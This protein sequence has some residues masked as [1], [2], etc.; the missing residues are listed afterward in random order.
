MQKTWK[1]VWN[2][3]TWVFIWD[4]SARALQW[5]QTWKVYVLFKNLCIMVF[6]K[7]IA[8]ALERLIKGAL[9]A[10]I[11]ISLYESN[12]LLEQDGALLFL[13]VIPWGEIFAFCHHPAQP[14]SS[15]G[16]GHVFQMGGRDHF[17]PL[18]LCLSYAPLSSFATQ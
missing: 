6:W 4:Y 15:T 11:H 1:N 8:S 13:S 7:K 2:S 12:T 5:I 14:L 17:L 9:K 18:A 16:C 10:H 3:G